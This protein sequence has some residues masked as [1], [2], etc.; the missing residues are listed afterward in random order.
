MPLVKGKSKE[1]ISENIATER[2]AGRPEKQAIAIAMSEAGKEKKKRK[3]VID[4]AY[5]KHM[6]GSEE[7]I[8]PKA[9]SKRKEM[10]E[11]KKAKE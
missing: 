11:M 7:K 2:K 4:M 6:G 5:K 9:E 3:D 8:E 1:A 10:A